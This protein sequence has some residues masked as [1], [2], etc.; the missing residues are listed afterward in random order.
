MKIEVKCTECGRENTF[1]IDQKEFDKCSSIARHCPCSRMDF[2]IGCAPK[3]PPLVDR[4]LRIAD[5]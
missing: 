2:V 4:Q 1:E 3:K 5:E